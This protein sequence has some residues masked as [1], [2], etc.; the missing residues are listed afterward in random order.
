MRVFL[1]GNGPSLARTNLDLIAD[2]PSFGMNRIHLVYPQTRWRPTYFMWSDLPQR[3]N[4]R[5]AL[6]EHI[7]SREKC[8][9]RRDVYDQLLGRWRAFPD[10]W[11]DAEAENVTAWDFH[12]DHLCASPGSKH[13]PD[14]WCFPR[15]AN[16]LCKLGTGM[17]PMMQQAIKLGYNELYLLGCDLDWHVLEGDDDSNHF[18]RE[19]E[20]ELEVHTA[21]RARFNNE[22]GKRMHELAAEWCKE[23]GIWVFNATIGGSLEAYPRANLEDVCAASF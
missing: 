10:P 2:E 1:V 3:E 5:E 14:K 11:L 9:V 18:S 7:Q 15:E 13:W 12:P 23:N 22:L 20:A 8:Y 17:G 19:Y 21:D 16:V 6:L 4:D